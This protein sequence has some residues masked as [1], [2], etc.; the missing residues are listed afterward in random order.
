MV[1][2][3]NFPV[4]PEATAVAIAY[5]NP[6]FH[7]IG[8][9]VMPRCSPVGKREF[10]YLQYPVGAFFS[11]PDDTI[12]RTG[13]ANEIGTEVNKVTAKAEDHGLKIRLP[14]ADIDEARSLG[15][16]PVNEAVG[17][18]MYFV[19]LNREV[20]VAG[21]AADVNNYNSDNV[22]AL[23][24]TDKWSDQASKPLEQLLEVLGGPLM[25]PNVM[26]LSGMGWHKL[27]TNINAIK[28]IK[29]AQG[30]GALTKKQVAE[31]LEI[32]E[33]LVG[34]ARVNIARKGQ[35]MNLQ[36]CWGNFC[37]LH[38][39]SK[40]ANTKRGVTWGMTVPKGGRIAGS[41]PEKEIGL[42]GGIV[43]LA[44][45]IVGEVIVGADCGALLQ[46]IY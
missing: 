13:V 26:S 7:L 25:R 23:S 27:R 5:R 22:Q 38:F 46:N 30:E 17:D 33:I 19:T 21:M 32:N 16:N 29:G 8:D 40:Q 18:I 14:K 39:R 35:D 1:K 31:Y 11:T 4:D 2:L 24:G 20:R 9:E 36:S 12:G 43:T 37:A 3:A 6:D 10:S 34:E 42:E 44:G 15:L 41:W 28:A 45:E